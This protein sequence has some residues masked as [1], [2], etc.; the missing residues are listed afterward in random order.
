[1]RQKTVRRKQ[2]ICDSNFYRCRAQILEFLHQARRIERIPCLPEL[3]HDKPAD[4]WLV[5]RPRGE[6][7]E[8]I[9]ITRLVALI[10]GADFLG[11]DLG[12]RCSTRSFS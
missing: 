5:K 8:V 4:A 9:D 3:E 10:A 12:E 7:S 2:S 6:C 1:M 11:K